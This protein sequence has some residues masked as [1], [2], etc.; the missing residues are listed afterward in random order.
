MAPFAMAYQICNKG[1]SH[2]TRVLLQLHSPAMRLMA[3][4]G[5]KVDGENWS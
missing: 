2:P 5:D 3:S 1:C 4:N